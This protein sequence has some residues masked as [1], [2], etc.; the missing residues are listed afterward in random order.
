MY[1]QTGEKVMR[2]QL[3][4]RK[5]MT[6][7]E[8]LV[9]I[10]VIAVLGA[11]LMA[12]LFPLL[13][14]SKEMAVYSELT[15]I[16][17]SL[18]SFK[19]KYGFYPPSFKS[20][21]NPSLTVPQ[22]KAAFARYLNRISPNHRENVSDWWDNVGSQIDWQEGEDLV[23]WLSG[24]FTNKQYPLTGDNLG[25]KKSF[26]VND[27]ANTPQREVFFEFKSD[28]IKPDTTS[29]AAKYLQQSDDE[30][31]QY[32][33]LDSSSYGILIPGPPATF[34]EYQDNNGNPFNP[35]TFQLCAPGLDKKMGLGGRLNDLQAATGDSP[36]VNLDNLCNFADGKL[37][38]YINSISN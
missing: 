7:V 26:A 23:F 4:T 15:Q 9:A 14:R 38:S 25:F 6:L 34:I 18:E 8:I 28:R 31:T 35:Q 16:N 36:I 13:N 11:M 10:T 1:Q 22:K 3:K 27:A 37:E 33:Y 30:T 17:Q 19:T 32:L 29:W 12:G 21:A 24:L 20:F 5:G 2:G